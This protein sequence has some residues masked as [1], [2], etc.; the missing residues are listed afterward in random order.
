MHYVVDFLTIDP[1]DWDE[2]CKCLV[3]VRDHPELATLSKT[4]TEYPFL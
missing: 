4:Y 2:V 1:W 3:I